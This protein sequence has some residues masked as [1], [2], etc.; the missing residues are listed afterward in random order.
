P[1]A[2]SFETSDEAPDP[3]K[4]QIWD[5]FTNEYA[6][7]TWHGIVTCEDL[8][9]ESIPRLVMRSTDSEPR[10]R[11][12]EDI[13]LWLVGCPSAQA[14]FLLVSQEKPMWLNPIE[15]MKIK[16]IDDLFP[17]VN[18]ISIDAFT[19]TQ[20][21][22]SGY[23]FVWLNPEASSTFEIHVRNESSPRGHSQQ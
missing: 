15:N 1:K 3:S 8:A 18:D 6:G 5:C 16:D 20:D 2:R 11:L 4:Y 10:E 23:G 7:S 17:P 13:R 22:V 12:L 21:S 14:V 9:N 19:Y